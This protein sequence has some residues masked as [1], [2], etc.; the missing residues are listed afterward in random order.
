MKKP[1]NFQ[2]LFE[3]AEGQSGFFTARQAVEAG[4]SETNH[5]Y[6]VKAGN[7]AKEGRGIY[8]LTHFPRV[9]RPDLMLWYLWSRNRKDIPQGV[10]SHSTAFSL[11]DL[12]DLN[13]SKLHMT[14]P[15]RFRRATPTPGVLVLHK[16]VLSPEDVTTRF[17]VKVT[18]PIRTVVD[19]IGSGKVEEGFIRQGLREGL[20]QG[21][22]RREE[23]K[24]VNASAEV[25]RQ[26]KAMMREV[27]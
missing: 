27:A 4:F 22:I 23:I 25:L 21:L 18:R 26:L 1:D 12:S 16:G 19:L 6:H 8:R 15:S 14:V 10:Y 13:P 2:K 3:V 9:D 11:F 5:P 24:S 20:Q 17:G 7:W